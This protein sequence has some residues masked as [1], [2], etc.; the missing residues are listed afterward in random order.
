MGCA[1]GLNRK[2]EPDMSDNE[3]K[4]M[5][6]K[7][8]TVFQQVQKHNWNTLLIMESQLEALLKKVESTFS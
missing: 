2:E 1:E 8:A 5:F 4:E 7:K 3:K 6:E